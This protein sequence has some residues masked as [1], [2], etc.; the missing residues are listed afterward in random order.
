V[1]EDGRVRVPTGP[2]LGVEPIPDILKE[3]TS[4]V[5]TLTRS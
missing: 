2:G 5:V 1:L 4:S 3:V